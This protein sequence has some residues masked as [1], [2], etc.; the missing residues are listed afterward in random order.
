MA[1]L[2]RRRRPIY[3]LAA[4]YLGA[5]AIVPGLYGDIMAGLLARGAPAGQLA[6]FRIHID[7]DDSHAAVMHAILARRLEEDPSAIDAVY[8][9]SSR[10]IQARMNF[11]T[12]IEWEAS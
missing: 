5:E 3:G 4:L 12:N 7:G 2:C 1:A 9:A 11:F 8:L 6:Y 10:A